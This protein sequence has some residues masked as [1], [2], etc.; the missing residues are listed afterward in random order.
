MLSM[1]FLGETVF[2]FFLENLTILT[3]SHG[4]PPRVK[5]EYAFFSNAFPAL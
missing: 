2:G 5:K 1:T 3:F 4:S